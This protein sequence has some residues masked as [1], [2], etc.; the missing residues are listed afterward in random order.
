MAKKKLTNKEVEELYL[1]IWWE[2]SPQTYE[3]LWVDDIEGGQMISDCAAVY[4]KL[5]RNLL[6]TLEE[7]AAKKGY[8]LP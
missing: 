4:P 2:T 6:D 1:D 7:R 3:S 5:Y 8:I